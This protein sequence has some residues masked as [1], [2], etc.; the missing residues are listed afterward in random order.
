MTLVTNNTK[1]MSRL[2]GI[3]LENWTEVEDNRFLR[4]K[5]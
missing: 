3:R 1:H 2:E 4:E 5:K